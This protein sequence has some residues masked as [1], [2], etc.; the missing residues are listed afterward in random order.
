MRKDWI[1]AVG[2]VIFLIGA[3]GGAAQSRPIVTD[4]TVRHELGQVLRQIC[5]WT[6]KVELRTG[7]LKIQEKRRTSIFIN[8]NLARVLIAAYTIH[9][10]E[11]YLQEAL[12]WFDR[13]VDLQQVA[14]ATN[15]DT[16]GWWGD[17]SPTANIY[18][19]D[20]GTSATA[21]AGA[22]RF[23]D[24]A[25]RAAYVQALQRYATFVRF[26]CKEDPQAQGRGGSP[27]WITMTGP[28]RGAIGTGYYK[29]K[30]ATAPYTIAT[31]VTGCGFF[32]ALYGLTHDPASLEIAEAAG[33]WL[34][35]KRAPDGHMPYTI[36][37]RIHE[38][39]PI[40][41]LSYV[42]DG[43]IGLYRRTPNESMKS[44]IAASIN[45]NVNW[46]INQQNSQGLWGKMRSEDQ[47]RSQGAINLMVLYYSDVSPEKLVLESIERNYRFFLT[48]ENLQKF[49]IFELSISTGFA[50]LSIAEVLEPGITYRIE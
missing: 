29:G 23:T 4:A 39:W 24:G 22:V 27:G 30:L 28:D 7:E 2:I 8:S 38:E 48:P 18:F 44:A 15:G 33:R 46:L 47:Q 20:A 49:G 6:I 3:R 16:A 41:T 14:I 17:F 50:G 1:V 31:S 40:N 10:E 12:A 34:L 25:R 5:D 32:S 11:A 13:L 43:L 45:R 36:E 35:Q 37:N 9:G 42:S 19:G 21:L 26:G